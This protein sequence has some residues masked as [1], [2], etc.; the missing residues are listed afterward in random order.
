MKNET[1]LTDGFSGQ[2]VFLYKCAVL[3]NVLENK[4][5]ECLIIGSSITTSVPASLFKFKIIFIILT[6]GEKRI[7]YFK[8]V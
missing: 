3:V 7:L 5:L 2:N 8:S 4:I 1:L 6:I